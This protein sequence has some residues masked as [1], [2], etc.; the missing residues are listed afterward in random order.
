MD[1]LDVQTSRVQPVAAAVAGIIMVPLGLAAIATGLTS[2]GGIVPVAIGVVMLA[3][4]GL[5]VW[6]GR[7]AH[8]KSVRYFSSDGLERNDGRWLAWADLDRVVYQVRV[9]RAGAKGLWR[10][11]I[12]FRNGEAA[13]LVP[14]RIRNGR[15]V[16]DFVSRLQ[17]DH[18]EER[19]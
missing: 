6:L 18:V 12:R 5:V 9:N 11:E 3:T 16:S 10:T 13:W 8:A 15:D 14:L 19:V 2:G 4:F 1:R 7:R 17:C